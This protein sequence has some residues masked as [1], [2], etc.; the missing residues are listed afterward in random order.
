MCQ[1][2]AG[3]LLATVAKKSSWNLKKTAVCLLTSCV[4]GANVSFKLGTSLIQY[5]VNLSLIEGKGGVI[6]HCG[7]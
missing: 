5:V 4:S 3:R 2:V 6:N 7:Q 1:E